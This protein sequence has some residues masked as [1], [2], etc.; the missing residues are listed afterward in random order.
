MFMENYEQQPRRIVSE[1]EQTYNT[2]GPSRRNYYSFC[3]G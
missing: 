2:S 3:I 1:K